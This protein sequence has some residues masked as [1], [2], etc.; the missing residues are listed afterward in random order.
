MFLPPGALGAPRR[1]KSQ[2]P[3]AFPAAPAARRNRRRLHD[4]V[5]RPRLHE[6]LRPE[7]ESVRP[8]CMSP[9]RA[10][11]ALGPRP[12]PR[13][14]WIPFGWDCRADPPLNPDSHPRRPPAA[15]RTG[16]PLPAVSPGQPRGRTRTIIGNTGYTGPMAKVMVS[17]P[18]DLLRAVDVEAERRGTTRSG[19]LREL[20]EES[21]QRRVSRR[22]RRM[23]AID[24]ASRQTAGHG[25]RVAELVKASRPG[26]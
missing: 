3:R 2:F 18:D 4:L 21:L 11:T 12:A 7:Q 6:R 23:A 9:A 5:Q 19:L 20:A 13:G 22:A 25:G 24:S 8:V 26:P 17:L 10:P 14:R 1:G 16:L 15:I